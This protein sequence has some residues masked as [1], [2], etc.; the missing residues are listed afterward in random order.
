MNQELSLERRLCARNAG[1]FILVRLFLG[2][3]VFFSLGSMFYVPVETMLTAAQSIKANAMVFVGILAV[4]FFM[5]LF[6]LIAAIPLNNA[7]R[8]VNEQLSY[9]AAILR[10]VEVF[11]FIAGIVLLFAES[12][13]FYQVFLV[14]I[15]TYALHLIIV[16]YLVFKSGYLNSFVGILVVI[17]GSMGYLL[18]SLVHAFVPSLSPVSTVGVFVAIMAESVLALTLI[19]KAMRMSP[20]S[21][22]TKERVIRI[23]EKMGEATT[24]EIIEEA[25]KESQECKDRVPANLI[26]LEGEGAI[27]KRLSKEKKGYVW[28][29]TS[30]SSKLGE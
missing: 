21:A 22:G 30:Q 15:F 2:S 19:L 25:S 4:L 20:E 13:L 16:G 23:L 9:R 14:S 17:G 8:A 24:A 6:S 10:A 18:E 28:S 7:L 5:S 3:L 27:T 11:I 12:T 1:V 29:L 26:L